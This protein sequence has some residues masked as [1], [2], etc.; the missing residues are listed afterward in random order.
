MLQNL[1]V[2]RIFVAMKSSIDSSPALVRVFMR[3]RPRLRSIASAMLGS[4]SEADDAV[5]EAFIRLWGRREAADGSEAFVAVRSA[6]IDALRRRRVRRA[7]SLDTAFN[8]PPDDSPPA[9]PSELY[10]E[11]SALID[12]QLSERE[13]TILLLRDRDEWEFESIASRFDLSES[14]VRMILSRARQK[15]R[16]IYLTRH[17]S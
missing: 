13:K 7:E 12:S 11:V 1:Y 15:V 17:Q 9:E 8:D 5:Q 16:Q 10:E 4:E 6:S 3:L 14:N 2:V